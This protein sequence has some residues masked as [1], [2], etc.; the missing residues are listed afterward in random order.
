MRL[1]LI[2]ARLN[3]FA[4]QDCLTI[5]AEQDA[6][7][8]PVVAGWRGR[9]LRLFRSYGVR[10]KYTIKN[11]SEGIECYAQKAENQGLADHLFICQDL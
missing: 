10:S 6:L 8:C 3:L 1:A 11:D 7:V 5:M 4:M 9:M 2:V